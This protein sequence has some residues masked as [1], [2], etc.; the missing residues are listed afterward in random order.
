MNQGELHKTILKSK[1]K[2]TSQTSF[3]LSYH[4]SYRQNR[5]EQFNR[6]S[7]YAQIAT[8]FILNLILAIESMIKVQLDYT[9]MQGL[10][11]I[12]KPFLQIDLSKL[13]E[14]SFI[15]LSESLD[16]FSKLS[17]LKLNLDGEMIKVRHI[18]KQ[19]KYLKKLK[20]IR[21]NI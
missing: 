11:N 1:Q 19:S 17:N 3:D 15:S 4:Y 7:I 9:G 10:Q 6:F 13:Q 16:I 20:N 5:K 14:V 12:E 18:P 8:E 21:L 2:I